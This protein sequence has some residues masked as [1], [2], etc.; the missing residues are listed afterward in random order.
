MCYNFC[1]KTMPTSI[2]KFVERHL[3]TIPN[4]KE[5]KRGPHKSGT[6]E[7]PGRQDTRNRI[8]NVYFGSLGAVSF[9]KR[10]NGAKWT[11]SQTDTTMKQTASKMEPTVFQMEAKWTQRHQKCAER[12]TTKTKHRC[13]E[14]VGT[15]TTHSFALLGLDFC[16]FRF[17]LKDLYFEAKTDA[18]THQKSM[19]KQV[20]KTTSKSSKS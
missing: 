16:F 5:S 12:R 17:V 10:Q 1:W 13:P 6:R 19:P 3:Q 4:L 15:G 11:W 7:T 14:K 8:K 2:H 18:Q 9:L 20:S